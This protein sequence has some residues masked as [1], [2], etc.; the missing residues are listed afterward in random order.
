M[1]TIRKNAFFLL[2]CFLVLA[3]SGCAGKA[4]PAPQPSEELLPP[5]GNEE[6]PVV[7]EAVPPSAPVDEEIPAVA[8]MEEAAAGAREGE[9]SSAD[10]AADA[11]DVSELLFEGAKGASKSWPAPEDAAGGGILLNFDNAALSDVIMELADMLGINYLLETAANGTVTIHSAAPMQAS[12]LYPV[13]LQVLEANGLTAV[14]V[15][16]LYHI[17]SSNN[18]SRMPL[19]SR[20]GRSADATAPGE[21]FVMQVVP[22]NFISCGEMSKLLTPFLSAD[23]TVVTHPDMNVMIIVDKEINIAKALKL[24]EVFDAD[25][26]DGTGHAIFRL[27]SLDAEETVGLVQEYLDAY[28]GDTG[29]DTRIISVE[30]LNALIVFSRNER[31]LDEI[32]AFLE[33]L[34]VAVY[35][36]ESQIY[37]Y[38]VRNGEASDLSSLLNSVFSGSEGDKSS[39]EGSGSSGLTEKEQE[40]ATVFGAP[41]TRESKSGE[42]LSGTAVGSGSLRGEVTITPDEIRN[43]LIIEAVPSDYRLIESVLDKL[44]VLPRQVL[45]EVTVAEITLDNGLDLG[46]EWGYEYEEGGSPSLTSA[47]TSAISDDG[48]SLLVQETDRWTSTLVALASDKKVNI[49]SSPSI[50]ASDNKTASIN[51]ATEIPVATAQYESTSDSDSVLTTSIQYRNTGVILSVTPHINEFGLVSMEISQEV[52]EEADLDTTV[53]DLPAFFERTINT[54]LTVSDGQTIVIGGLISEKATKTFVG[55]PILKDL[56]LLKYL[57]GTE[58]DSVSKTELILM[59]TPRVIASLEDVTAVTN[60]F[61]A[62]VQGI[63]K[64][65]SQ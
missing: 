31:V 35:N 48:L 29:S 38:F 11:P 4:S 9:T 54:T 39:Q 8:E 6:L 24:V 52:S 14:Q 22:L 60:E 43:A 10:D 37:V 27:K 53:E 56:P 20:M 61:K 3:G 17:G 28:G 62:K 63:E 40:E 1:Q 25:V 5:A 7:P 21:R 57:F 36:Q 18:V 26:F 59:I 65:S 13:F 16:D 55:V 45:I 58:N 46:V 42:A 47:I 51:I 2:I 19:V 32:D 12:Q 64:F 30:R 44:D 15:G 50:L 41:V 34:D 49:L 33:T 23:G